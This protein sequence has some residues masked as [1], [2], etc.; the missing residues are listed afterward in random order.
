MSGK[1]L[2]NIRR[3][4]CR[5]REDIVNGSLSGVNV[6]DPRLRLMADKATL[7]HAAARQGWCRLWG[8][9][10]LKLPSAS[11]PCA[12]FDSRSKTSTDSSSTPRSRYLPLK[13]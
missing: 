8:S 9:L 10:M 2:L 11:I 6:G 7:R 1:L 5:Y 3:A 4:S 13:T 12:L